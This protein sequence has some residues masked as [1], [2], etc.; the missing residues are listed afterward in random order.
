MR[1]SPPRR[2]RRRRRRGGGICP[3]LMKKALDSSCSRPLPGESPHM[4]LK[5]MIAVENS[6]FARDVA[7]DAARLFRGGETEF[8]LVSI[9]ESS[10]VLTDAPELEPEI[11][12]DEEAE[13]VALH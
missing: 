8:F 10:P 9:V 13:F 3:I 6:P 5:I 11:E 1:T 12:S 4:A 7:D 2:R